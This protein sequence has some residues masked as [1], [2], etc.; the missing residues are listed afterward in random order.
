MKKTANPMIGGMIWAP[1]EA[2]ASTAAASSGLSPTRF[3]SG[4]VMLPDT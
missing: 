1:L 4:M 2:A 3:M